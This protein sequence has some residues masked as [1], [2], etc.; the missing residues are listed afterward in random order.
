[1]D[2][3][4]MSKLLYQ[5]KLANQELTTSFEKSTGFSLTRYE[6]M[7]F[8]LEKDTCLQSD[9]QK[10][11]HIDSAAVTRH[12]KYLEAKGYVERERNQTNQREV[13][14]TI[15]ET[16]RNELLHCAQEHAQSRE[17]FG[18]NLDDQEQKLLVDLLTKLIQ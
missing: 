6:L 16:A 14:V 7:Q 4:T 17:Q 2:L 11:L 8:L 9:L 5:L 15:T 10:E 12:L 13:L 3:R 18:L 1:M